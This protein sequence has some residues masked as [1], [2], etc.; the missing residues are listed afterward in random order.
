[1]FKSKTHSINIPQSEHGRLAG[2]LASLWGNEAFER[3]ALDFAAFVAGVTLHD[4]NYALVDTLPIMEAGEAEW[5]AMACRGV[6]HTFANPITDIVVKLHLKRLLNSHDDYPERQELVRV[7]DQQIALRLPQTDFTL[8][9]FLWADKITRF[10]DMVAFDF[11]FEQP[12]SKTVDLY[13]CRD[14]SAITPVSYQI[15][16]NGIIEIDPWPLSVPAYSGF[17]L[18]YQREGYPDNLYPQVIA[19]HLTP[20]EKL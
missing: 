9:Q 6:A 3:P 17:I 4:W 10:C 19:Y 8:A 16:G 13:A 1:M 18:G 12:T 7:I 14:S 2:V 5:L 11:S 15:K 20:Q